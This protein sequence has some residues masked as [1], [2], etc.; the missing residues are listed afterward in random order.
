MVIAVLDTEVNDGGQLEAFVIV[1]LNEF[2]RPLAGIERII[3]IQRQT[4]SKTGRGYVFISNIPLAPS[5]HHIPAGVL[6]D[7]KVVFFHFLLRPF[8]RFVIMLC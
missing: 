7:A 3:K 1:A 8:D 2:T 6:T 5:C 4:F